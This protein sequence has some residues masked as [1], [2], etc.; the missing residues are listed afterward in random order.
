[1]FCTEN[2]NMLCKLSH[3]GL[4][5]LFLFSFIYGQTSAIDIK[6]NSV[7]KTVVFGNS[8]ISL[9]L[10]Y[11]GKCSISELI[12]NGQPVVTGQNCIYSEIVT[13]TGS[14]STLKLMSEPAINIGKNSVN[15]SNITY[16]GNDEIVN[17]NWKFIITE[18]DVK[19]DIERNFPKSIIIEEAAFP[20]FTFNS[21]NTWNGAFLEYGGLAWFYL[22]NSKL[23]TYG[24]HSNSSVFWNSTTGNALKI[25]VEAPEKKVAMKYSRTSD[26]KLNYTIS[27]SDSELTCRYEKEK[28][29]RFIRGKTDVWDRFTCCFRKICAIH[30][31]V[32]CKL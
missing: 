3:V 14:Y 19:F 29:S 28:R 18:N 8:N 25:S 22:F 11:N 27:V 17:E 12:V 2:K 6:N 30:Y 15:I 31:H 20:S 13:S 10:D 23:C 21:I 32:L 1:M 4:I 5:V 16:G 24:V 9:T 7:D 26:D